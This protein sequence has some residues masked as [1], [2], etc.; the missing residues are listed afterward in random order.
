MDQQHN[1]LIV[2]DIELVRLTIRY[3]L[4]DAYRFYEA[5]DGNSALSLV[6]SYPINLVVLDYQMPGI[7]GLET[8]RLI[9]EYNH[10]IQVFMMSAD[11]EDEVVAAAINYGAFAFLDKTRDLLK[12][13]AVLKDMSVG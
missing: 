3:Y 4:K 12:I 6:Q 1:L 2:D 9:K 5:T 11:Y 13:R 7:D 8:L 10:S